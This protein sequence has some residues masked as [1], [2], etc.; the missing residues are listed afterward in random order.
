MAKHAIL[1]KGELLFPCD[2]FWVG[3]R[4][5]QCVAIIEPPGEIAITTA[6]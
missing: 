2:V 3:G 6:V 5:G 4:A 1:G